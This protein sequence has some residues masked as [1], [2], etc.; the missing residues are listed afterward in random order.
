MHNVSLGLNVEAVDINLRLFEVPALGCVLLQHDFPRIAELG[1]KDA[2]NCFIFGDET[3][4]LKRILYA[5]KYPEKLEEIRLRGIGWVQ[6][7][8]WDER[9]KIFD[10]TLKE[11]Q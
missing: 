3:D 9:A 4:L 1:L 11:H 7:Q 8:T 2:H 10:K 5:K 6:S